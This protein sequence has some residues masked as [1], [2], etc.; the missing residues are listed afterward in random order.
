V[1]D[2]GHDRAG[3]VLQFVPFALSPKPTFAEVA[4]RFIERAH[5]LYGSEV[6]G[7]AREAFAQVGIELPVPGPPEDPDCGQ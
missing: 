7:P 4:R 6:Y 3:H 2:V 5:D 1:E